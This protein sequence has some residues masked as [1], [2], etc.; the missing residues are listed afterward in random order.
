MLLDAFG[1]KVWVPEED[2]P[3]LSYPDA[4]ADRTV[5]GDRRTRE[6]VKA[7]CQNDCYFVNQ[8]LTAILIAERGYSRVE[9]RDNG[10]R[11][12]LTPDER[13]ELVKSHSKSKKIKEN[14]DGNEEGEASSS[15]GEARGVHGG[16]A[17]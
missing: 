12:G 17:A 4:W 14:Q 7:Q 5:Y 13:Y 8:C 9:R 1:E 3:C 2:T 6:V 11:G 15:T 10:I 16:E